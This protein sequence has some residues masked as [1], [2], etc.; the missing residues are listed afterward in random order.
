MG[1]RI[2]FVHVAANQGNRFK[3]AVREMADKVNQSGTNP[4]RVAK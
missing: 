1:E 4:G 3:A 2:D